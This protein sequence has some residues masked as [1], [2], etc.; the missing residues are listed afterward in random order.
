MFFTL[1]FCVST[2]IKLI[3]YVSK[4]TD[5]LGMWAV[6]H[7]PSLRFSTSPHTKIA[8]TFPLEITHAHM[9]T[10]VRYVVGIFVHVPVM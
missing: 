6:A 3:S 5:A 9:S 4:L 8:E 1:P 7:V 2:I 10:C